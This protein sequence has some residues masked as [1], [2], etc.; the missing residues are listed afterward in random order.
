M[1]KGVQELVYCSLGGAGE[2]GM[3]LNLFGYGKPGEYKWIIV[4]IGVTFSDDNIPGIEVILPNPEF[5]ASQKENLLGIVLTHAH[6]DHVGAIAHLWPMLECPIYA[7]PFTAAIVR[8]KFKEKK[9]NIGSHLK[10]VKLGGNVKLGAFDIDYVTLT[11]SILEPNGLA[12]TT[13][14]GVVLH[15]ADWKIDEDPLIGEKTDVKKLTELGKKGVLAMVC[16]STNIFNIGSSGSES[17]VRT[18]LL[19]VLEKMK[20]RIVITSF[21][22]NVARMET[23]FKVAEKI[24]RHVCLVGRSMNRIYELARQCNYLQDIK[25]PIDVRDS[26]KMPKNKMVF[27]CTGSQGE[28]R[29]ALARIANGTHPDLHLE[30]DDNVIFSSRI[31]PGNEKR[32]YKI[33]N[34]FSKSEIN[35]LSEENSMIHVS[36]HPAREDLK[37][38]YNWVKPKIL[39]PVH[40]EQRHMAE[41]INFAKEMGVKFPIKVSNGEIIRLAPGEPQVVDK[42]TSGRVYLD[43]KVLIDNDSPVLKERRNMAANGYMEIT[44]LISKNGQIKNNPII[45]LKGIPFIEEDASEIEYDLEDVVMDTCKSFNLNNSKQEKNLI[46]TLKGNCRKLINDKSGKKPFV[47]INL[48]RF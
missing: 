37:K 13:P 33:F 21:A 31:I 18:G 28:Q 8:E 1:A 15:T 5:I 34:D 11:H 48:V 30:K 35:V 19:T 36:G 9:I 14:E 12:I 16:D 29:A 20:N 2:I 25:V 23:V 4:D 46:D 40:G 10:I 22:S 44:V 41:H 32:L 43:G 45:T 7:T 47:N 27:L 38:M 3:N 6:E 26:K 24:G 42:V 17:L 39:I